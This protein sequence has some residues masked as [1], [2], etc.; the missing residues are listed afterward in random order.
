MKKI[1][2]SILAIAGIVIAIILFNTF[3]FQSNQIEVEP[4]TPVNVSDDVFDRFSKGIQYPTISFNSGEIYDSASFLGFHEFIQTSY[5]LVDSL[6]DKE[7]INLSLL[8]KWQGSDL[9]LKPIILM[10]HQDVV[11]IDEPTKDDWEHGP[12][13]GDITD[14][15][16]W[17]RGTMDDKGTLLATLEAVEMMLAEG[18]QPKR[19]IYLA[20]GHDEEVGGEFGAAA[21]VEHLKDQGVEAYFTLDE[22]GVIAEGMLPGLDKK[23]ALINVAEKGYVSFELKVQTGGGH[24]ST[25][26]ENNTIGMLAKAIVALEANQLPYKLERPV[27]D[28]LN[29]LGPELPFSM[30]MAFANPWLFKGPI[31]KTLN[32]HTSTAPTIINAGI[33][34]NVIPTTAV[35]TVNFRVFPGETVETVRQHIISTINNDQIEVTAPGLA[36]E[37]SPVSSIASES[38]RLLSKTIRQLHP[39]AVVVPGLLPGGTDSKHFIPISENVYRFYPIKYTPETAHVFHGINER[40]SKDNYKECIQFVYH[41]IKN[42]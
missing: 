5:P 29:A 28:Q 22:G 14:T 23:M 17:G 1:L 11:P 18:Y 21:I 34:D 19:T 20:F 16:V 25:P 35:A 26:P 38:Y 12:F 6:L 15:D 7:T 9:S 3:T 33:K 40:L 39:G 31:L 24:S 42:S 2:L 36:T 30:K 10:S 32:A 27:S 8:Y 37:A 4:V 41:L 13:S